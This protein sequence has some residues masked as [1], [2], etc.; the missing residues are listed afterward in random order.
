MNAN[1]I[2]PGRRPS[3]ARSARRDPRAEFDDRT[4]RDDRTDRDDPTNRDTGDSAG[5]GS[6][7]RSSQPRTRAPSQP[8]PAE[9]EPPTTSHDPELEARVF[10]LLTKLEQEGDGMVLPPG[11][12]VEI[13]DLAKRRGFINEHAL[14]LYF[15]LRGR[16]ELESRAQPRPDPKARDMTLIWPR[17]KLVLKDLAHETGVTMREALGGVVG[18]V[19]ENRDALTRLARGAGLEHPWEGIGVLLKGLARK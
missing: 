4:N 5:S 12:W 3:S 13:A 1:R 7:R 14:R 19:Y 16:Q 18:I 8:P 9:S 17:D 2:K 10:M 15:T 11:P 6:R